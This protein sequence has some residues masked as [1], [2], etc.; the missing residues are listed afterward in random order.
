MPPRSH[1]QRDNLA[2]QQQIGESDRDRRAGEAGI[3]KIL[4]PVAQVD[5]RMAGVHVGRTEHKLDLPI[6]A[7]LID[8]LGHQD[9]PAIRPRDKCMELYVLARRGLPLILRRVLS[10]NLL[11]ST[12]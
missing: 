6:I 9:K 8:L 11:D 2:W 12:L 4:A 1:R 5:Q 10:C 7:P 3:I